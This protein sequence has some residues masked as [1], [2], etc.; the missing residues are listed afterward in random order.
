MTS[1]PTYQKIG[2]ALDR[3]HVKYPWYSWDDHC[4]LTFPRNKPRGPD[5][6]QISN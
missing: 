6:S 3:G 2:I 1:H 5:T 4:P